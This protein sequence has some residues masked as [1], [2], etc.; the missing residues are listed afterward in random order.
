MPSSGETPAEFPVAIGTLG[1]VTARHYASTAG[2]SPLLVLA[3]GAGADQRHRFMTT[4]GRLLSQRGI[5]VVTFNFL[6]TEMRK[7]GPDR[8]AVLEETWRRALD[9]IVD[10]L[11]PQGR[12]AIGG[13]SMGGRI[14]SMVAAAEPASDA[15]TRADGLVLLGYPLH[16]PGRPDAP[17]TAHL[18]SITMPILVVQGTRDTFGTRAEV[19]PIFSALRC[20][21]DF[22]FIE[23]GDH[24]FAVPKSTGRTE[25][26]VL[27]A[28]ADRVAQWLQASR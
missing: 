4:M 26:D 18:P 8:P 16:P 6:Y 27:A 20:P 25:G 7:R 21:V 23:Q 24:S 5:D 17:R 10:R 15:W 13:K 14:A 2:A 28:V 3:H 22:E 9:A 19:E 12:I 1:A 11:E